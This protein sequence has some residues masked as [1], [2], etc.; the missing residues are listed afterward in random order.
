MISKLEDFNCIH[1]D[2]PQRPVC[3]K[4]GDW[5]A[6]WRPVEAEES[7]RTCANCKYVLSME[8]AHHYREI[9]KKYNEYCTEQEKEDS[10]D[11]K[12]DALS[13]Y[14]ALNKTYLQRLNSIDQASSSDDVHSLSTL[15]YMLQSVK[16]ELKEK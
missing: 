14:K 3:P 4:C 13:M 12:D 1:C 9:K 6:I 8:E 2:K 10:I 15:F 7:S 16:N 5:T 11:Y